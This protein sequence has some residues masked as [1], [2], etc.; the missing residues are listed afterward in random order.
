MP[1]GYTLWLGGSA[2]SSDL[3]DRVHSIEAEESAE[4]SGTLRLRF[5]VSADEAGEV[6]P[7]GDPGVAPGAGVA[8]VA[9]AEGADGDGPAECVFDG[10]VQAHTLHLEPGIAGSYLD[11]VA[12]DS[13]WL[14]DRDERVREWSESSD[15]AVA[16]AI[17]AEHGFD[18]DPRNLENDSP[19]HGEATGTLL[20]RGS[21][22]Q[23]LR[24]LARRSGK[25]LLA[26]SGDAP[27]RRTGVF[28]LPEVAGAP[29][30]T[31]APNRFGAPNVGALDFDWDIAR[32]TRIQARQM[33]YSDAD[34]TGAT[35]DAAESGLAPMDARGIED[36]AGTPA[37][38]ILTT[39]T[40]VAD[41]LAQ[42]AQG[43]LREAG[44]FATV[45]GEA[46]AAVL[47]HVLR[48]G[49]IVAVEAVGTI[50]S[51][52]YL[53]WNVRHTIDSARH[54]MAFTL[55]RN[56]MGAAPAAAGGLL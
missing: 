28:A 8:L 3:L 12:R 42:R 35:G 15:G 43:A 29:V 1:G 46:D 56:A 25:M 51:G 41:T 31:L 47:G 37:T 27:E 34:G 16:N 32:P 7:A 2:A 49:Q 21:D 40:G 30:A 9:T 4:A 45:R 10:Y 33:L 11:V 5:A 22:W 13:S 55:A 23:L 38:A 39:I 52:R 50:H 14:L 53:V 6:A 48:V 54:L 36:F 20:Q 44:W 19:P 18:S 26:R 24:L 17:F